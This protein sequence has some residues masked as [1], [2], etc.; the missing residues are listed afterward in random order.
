MTLTVATRY[1]I[2]GGSATD[3]TSSAV[4]SRLAGPKVQRL[5]LGKALTQWLPRVERFA[6]I[7][8]STLN[9]RIVPADPPIPALNLGETISD[10]APPL[11]PLV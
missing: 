8:E 6:I 5:A 2:S 1:C 11:T 10:R 3:G 9:P 7:S 4:K